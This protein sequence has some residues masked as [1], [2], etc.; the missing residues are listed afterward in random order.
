MPPCL[1]ASSFSSAV[2]VT[3]L[4]SLILHQ[5]SS[6]ETLFWLSP[7]LETPP[8]SHIFRIF[9]F[10]SFY[11]PLG[12]V[13]F[14]PEA[15]DRFFSCALLIFGL[16]SEGE[17]P[18]SPH[19]HS[20]TIRGRGSQPFG[21][22]QTSL[23]VRA[24]ERDFHAESPYGSSECSAMGSPLGPLVSQSSGGAQNPSS[25]PDSGLG[26]M[27]HPRSPQGWEVQLPILD[28]ADPD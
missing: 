17:I 11:F 12:L 25:L 24:K 8:V 27:L 4:L 18:A 10:L 9:F 28:V 2:S 14:F 15:P 5:P 16:L 21:M 23:K 26:V 13:L 1:S 3:V 20:A 19:T 6:S 7:R 22:Y